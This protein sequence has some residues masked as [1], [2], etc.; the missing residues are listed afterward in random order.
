MTAMNAGRTE[1]LLASCNCTR[2]MSCDESRIVWHYHVLRYR[3]G[4]GKGTPKD[5][6][7]LYQSEKY[8]RETLRIYLLTRS[9]LV[10]GNYRTRK[11][12]GTLRNQDETPSLAV[13]IAGT[14]N[15]RR[16]EFHRRPDRRWN[17]CDPWIKIHFNFHLSGSTRG[18]LKLLTKVKITWRSSVPSLKVCNLS[19]TTWNLG[20]LAKAGSS[21]TDASTNTTI[22]FS[23]EKVSM[24]NS[25]TL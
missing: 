14:T 17:R 16:E 22:R 20:S 4:G 2:I 24:S 25:R 13:P 23:C 11:A 18:T 10:P 3:Q 5:A 12:W 21:R 6:D 9:S 15:W 8:H 1:E 19:R 7:S